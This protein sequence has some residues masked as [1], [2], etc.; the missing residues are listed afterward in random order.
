MARHEYSWY[1][2]WPTK[3]LTS[4]RWVNLTL[5]EEGFYRRMYDWASIS[6]PA[7][8]RGFMYLNGSPMSV[9][10]ISKT[11]HIPKADCENHLSSL[12]HVG[13]ITR[14]KAGAWGF[15]DFAR[16]QRGANLQVRK[17]ATK[18]MPKRDKSD[19][20]LMPKVPPEIDIEIEEETETKQQGKGRVK[21]PVNDSQEMST[22]TEAEAEAPPLR[23]GRNEEISEAQ[24]LVNQFAF[25]FPKSYHAKDARHEKCLEHFE[26]A[27]A[28]GVKAKHVRGEM[29]RLVEA[30]NLAPTPW[31]IC[32]P[33]DPQRPQVASETKAHRSERHKKLQKEY[34]DMLKRREQE[35]KEWT[36]TAS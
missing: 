4:T 31:E 12:K 18:Q 3:A 19:A 25:S 17:S 11:L 36:G 5:E 29:A 13:L 30:G 1:K 6:E 27:L 34:E 7:S 21:E 14:N 22:H 20:G 26:V 2:W 9:E 35:E 8:K 16:H 15:P 28:R 33:L 24:D 23:G 10:M 32:A